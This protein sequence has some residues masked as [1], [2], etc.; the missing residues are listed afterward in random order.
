MAYH[1]CRFVGELGQIYVKAT[2][3]SDEWVWRLTKRQRYMQ[4][5][6][7]SHFSLLLHDLY[8]AQT[9]LQTSALSPI[10]EEMLARDRYQNCCPSGGAEIVHTFDLIRTYLGCTA[11]GDLAAIPEEL[12][13]L[14]RV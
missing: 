3:G 7:L 4:P 11:I 9:D 13:V 8:E 14:E 12:A 5:T 1:A 6:P 10:H 2:D